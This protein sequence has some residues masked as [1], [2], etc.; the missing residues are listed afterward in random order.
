MEVNVSGLMWQ[1]HKVERLEYPRGE[2]FKYSPTLKE[3]YEKVERSHI[4][5]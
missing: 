3:D 1:E 2:M 4:S 5:G